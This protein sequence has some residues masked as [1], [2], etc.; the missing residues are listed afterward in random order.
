MLADPHL[1]N[2]VQEEWRMR[3][4]LTGVDQDTVMLQHLK[5]TPL[6]VRSGNWIG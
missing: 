3:N 2:R 6:G 1:L 4:S 5:R